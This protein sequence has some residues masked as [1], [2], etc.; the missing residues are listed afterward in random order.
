[1]SPT[2][3]IPITFK[4][5]TNYLQ[6][7]LRRAYIKAYPIFMNKKQQSKLHP[8]LLKALQGLEYETKVYEHIISPIVDYNICPNFIRVI[9]LGE[10]VLGKLRNFFTKLDSTKQRYVTRPLQQLQ[11][12]FI[13]GCQTYLSDMQ[14]Q[15]DKYKKIP[16]PN[17]AQ[18]MVTETHENIQSFRDVWLSTGFTT[19]SMNQFPCVMFQVAAACYVMSL[20]RMIHN[21]MHFSN[22]LVQ[23]LQHP[24]KMTYIYDEHM[25]VFYTYFIVYIFDFD[26]AHVPVLGTNP[27][28]VQNEHSSVDFTFML[29]WGINQK[30]FTNPIDR[31]KWFKQCQQYLN[32]NLN[33]STTI[34]PTEAM[35]V[36]KNRS[37][38]L[39]TH[40]LHS[41]K[42]TYV[43][44]PSMFDDKTGRLNIRPMNRRN[45]TH[46]YAK[47]V[48][49]THREFRKLATHIH[50]LDKYRHQL[51]NRQEKIASEIKKAVKLVSQTFKIPTPNQRKKIHV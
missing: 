50:T 15:D 5:H 48:N 29:Q 4:R 32:I 51:S 26:Q 45:V 21:D 44:H 22:I 14:I 47:M 19:S 33:D 10:C 8:Q 49:N 36:L 46:K 42:H 39:F 38:H 17:I 23:T 18:I 3:V 27:N 37:P 9:L 11:A 13:L 2:I 7:P 16:I 31:K 6:V 28:H 34:T 1:M 35:K 40:G 24:R 12:D 41:V 43:C 25:Y 30:W 20:S